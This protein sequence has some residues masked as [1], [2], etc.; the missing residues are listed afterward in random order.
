MT[1]PSDVIGGTDRAVS[2]FDL[3]SR[4]PGGALVVETEHSVAAESWPKGL[5]GVRHD[6]LGALR[7]ECDRGRTSRL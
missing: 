6:R 7:N 4:E 1:R 2:F 5:R 3:A